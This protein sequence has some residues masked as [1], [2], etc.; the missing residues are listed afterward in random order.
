MHVT[1]QSL[2]ESETLKIGLFE[3]RPVSD[4]CGDVE[5]QPSNVVV[6]PF[7]GVFSKHDAPGRSVV[8]TPSHAVFIAADTPY[9]LSFP[10]AIG[11]RALVFRFGEALIPEHGSLASHRLLPPDAI[12][13]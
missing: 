3:A 10:G 5:W 8:G 9:R 6:L 1:R 7:S 13:L 2:F 4:A 12:L 11:D